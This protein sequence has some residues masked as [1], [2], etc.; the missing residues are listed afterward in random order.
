MH[1]TNK[2]PAWWLCYLIWV[3]MIGLVVADYWAPLP[4]GVQKIFAVS[5]VLVCGIATICWV[6]ANR[7][8]LSSEE[9]ESS[10]NTSAVTPMYLY[11]KEKL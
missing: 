10:G 6:Y 11:E 8:Q 3:I 5:I 7:E 1:Q 9:D 2:K 4:D